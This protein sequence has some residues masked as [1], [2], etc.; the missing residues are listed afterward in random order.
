MGKIFDPFV[1][2]KPIGKGTGLGL[3]ICSAI[4]RKYAGRI[5]ARNEDE[6]VTMVVQLP[7]VAPPAAGNEEDE[8]P[9]PVSA[10]PRE[11]EV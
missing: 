8:V 3:S 2:T 9:E 6:G 1:T 7:L 5:E 4:V 11:E 10:G